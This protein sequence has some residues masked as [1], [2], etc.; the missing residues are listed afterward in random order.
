VNVIPLTDDGQV[1]LIRQWRQGSGDWTLEIPGG[2]IDSGETPLEAGARELGE[3]TGYQAGQMISLG[4]VNPNPAL[5]T[6]RCHTFL[7]RGCRLAGPA[8][9]EPSE[10]IETLIRPVG[11]LPGLVS[12]GQIRHSLVLS[13]LTF[14]WLH[15]DRNPPRGR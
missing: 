15:E 13:A 7:A 14:F 10:R 3:E 1:V 9:L 5:F 11:D 12:S 8:R 6:N 4:W 2:I